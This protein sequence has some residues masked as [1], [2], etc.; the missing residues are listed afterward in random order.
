SIDSAAALEASLPADALSRGARNHLIAEIAFANRS[1][2]DGV[3]IYYEGAAAIR[4]STDAAWYSQD[5]L[6]IAKTPELKEWYALPYGSTSRADWLRRFWTGRDL[7]DA[8]L[9]G[10]RLPEQF[11]RWRFALENYRWILDG[12]MALGVK[13]EQVN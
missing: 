11:R 7:Q 13:F 12:S 2:V 5:L 10:T 4:D 8:R 3:R 9:P 1:D 6:W